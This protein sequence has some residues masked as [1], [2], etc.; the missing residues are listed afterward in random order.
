MDQGQWAFQEFVNA[1]GSNGPTLWEE[2]PALAGIKSGGSPFAWGAV[3]GPTEKT[4][5]YATCVWAA[6]Q[7]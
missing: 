3:K 1:K 2:K 4:K 5:D 7:L 6:D